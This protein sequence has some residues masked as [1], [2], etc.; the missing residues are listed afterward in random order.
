MTT[1]VSPR[2]TSSRAII[3]A[4]LAAGFLFRFLPM[5]F[6]PSIAQPD[7]V[8]QAIEQGHRHFYGYGLVPWEFDYAAR[9][10]LLGYFAA[11]A[12]ALSEFF[13]G[14]PAIYLPLIA[15]LLS[16]LGAVSTL[17]AFLWGR[18]LIST[19]GGVAAALIS[20]TWVDTL[21]FGGRSLTE[22]VGAHFFVIALYLAEPGFRVQS[23][24]RLFFAGLFAGATLMLRI[25]L[26]PAVA[27]IWLWRITDIRRFALLSAGA[28]LAIIANGAFDAA[29][30]SYP[31][32]PLWQN[33]QFNLV[34]GGSHFFGTDPW[35]KYVYWMGANW[36]GTIALFLP[37][38]I[39]GGRRTPILLASAVLIVAVHS[40]LGHKE[41]RFIYPALL[42]FSITAGLGAVD[43]ARL[44]THGWRDGLLNPASR[45]VVGVMTFCWIV[46]C[47]VNLIGRDYDKHWDRAHE[48]TLA[49][50]HV[51]RMQ[52]VCGIGLYNVGNYETGG[53]SYFHKRVPLYWSRKPWQVM[54][55]ASG[56]NVMVYSA[57]GL[58]PNRDLSPNTPYREIA[59]YGKT[60]ILQRPGTCERLPLVKPAKSKMN[61]EILDQY[62][63]VAG[64]K[65]PV[66]IERESP[67]SKGNTSVEKPFAGSARNAK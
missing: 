15:G 35:W 42:L 31:F 21:Y 40:V 28:L 7:E 22:V 39:F 13:G 24:K 6:W 29:T 45:G 66:L 25:H 23:G 10:W 3:C 16:L 60:C 63:Y 9:S 64:I 53:Y 2:L 49:A 50:L 12:M 5:L 54:D 46:L 44:I 18:R 48:S 34:Q 27:L 14:G 58:V 65:A 19:A 8:I 33:I 61:T 59:C 11:G 67:P 62:P 47:F 51:S 1:N 4:V 36:G 30:W 57:K 56:F 20:A 41:Y 26:A 38:A 37:L 17:C 55:K 52:N 43:L 32:E